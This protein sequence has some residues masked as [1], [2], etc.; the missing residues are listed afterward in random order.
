M[1]GAGKANTRSLDNQVK[2]SEDEN[3]NSDSE[4]ESALLPGGVEARAKAFRG[5]EGSSGASTSAKKATA[6]T[7]KATYRRR[8]RIARWK[9]SDEGA[10][11]QEDK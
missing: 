9:E 1:P 3:S 6:R 7:K 11:K 10:K 8:R 2:L 4:Y 5:G